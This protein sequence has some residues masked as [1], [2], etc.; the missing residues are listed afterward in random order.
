MT[1]LLDLPSDLVVV[2][3]R[4]EGLVDVRQVSPELAEW[5]ASLLGEVELVAV[6]VPPPDDPWTLSLV[7]S[8]APLSV[9]PEEVVLQGLRRWAAARGEV[10]VLDLPAGTAVAT[11]RVEQGT[12]ALVEVL[13][14]LGRFLLTL[15]VCSPQPERLPEC[16]SLA[17]A[18]AERVCAA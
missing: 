7:V 2:A 11:A 12:A 15:A 9:G 1:V 13:L 16:A 5:H 3:A 14:P 17:A 8:F 4:D 18:V 6:R 10:Q